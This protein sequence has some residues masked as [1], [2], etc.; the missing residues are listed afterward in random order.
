M[1]RRVSLANFC[2]DS[3]LHSI[4]RAIKGRREQK[5]RLA[6]AFLMEEHASSL[7]PH[8][9]LQCSLEYKLSH[10][11]LDI[12]RCLQPWPQLSSRLFTAQ[13]RICSD[14]RRFEHVC[15]CIKSLDITS[16]I[17]RFEYNHHRRSRML[18]LHEPRR[19]FCGTSSHLTR[20]SRGQ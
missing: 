12:W 14:V 7:D 2:T 11:G 19:I 10:E 15:I 16:S 18:R 13:C 20:H 5:L 1:I 3:I 9:A 17:N 4:Q 6:F 8:A